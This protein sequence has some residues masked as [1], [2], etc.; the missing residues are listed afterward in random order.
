MAL[1]HAGTAASGANRAI[2]SGPGRFSIQRTSTPRSTP[3]RATQPVVPLRSSS[4]PVAR[5]SR[6]TSSP[7]APH[8]PRS[9]N[10][11]WYS[12]SSPRR[13]NRR[14]VSSTVSRCVVDIGRSARRATSVSESR[15]PPV[16]AVRMPTT[17][18]ITVRPASAE[19]PANG[20]SR[21]RTAAPP[22][23]PTAPVGAIS[24]DRLPLDGAS[25]SGEVDRFPTNGTFG[26]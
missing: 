21:A 4:A 10:P 13:S 8:M 1:A 14:W 19:F 7:P 23:P 11:A 3:S 24:A 15:S 9:A 22:E 26:Q 25:G 6:R 5:S 16:N 18:L 20:A 17:L 2:A 12:P